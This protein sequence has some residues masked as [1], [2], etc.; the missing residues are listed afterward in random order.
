MHSTKS[1]PLM[2][3]M[4]LGWWK[5]GSK[6]MSAGGSWQ[7]RRLSVRGTGDLWEFF[8]QLCWRAKIPFKKASDDSHTQ[9]LTI[10]ALRRLRQEECNLESTAAIQSQTKNKIWGLEKS[11]KSPRVASWGPN[12]HTASRVPHTRNHGSKGGRWSLLASGL[13]EIIQ[14]SGRQSASKDWE[15]AQWYGTPRVICGLYVCTSHKYL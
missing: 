8:A 2:K 4:D 5:C 7:W 13:A 3:I 11:L 15:G 14:A 9:Q 10:L 1:K 12:A 6:Q